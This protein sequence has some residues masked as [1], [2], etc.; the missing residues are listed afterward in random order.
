MQAILKGYI[1]KTL[2]LSKMSTIP[3]DIFIDENG[4]VI[5]SHYCRDT[6]DH[7]PMDELIEFSNG[8]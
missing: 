8:N 5:R 4:D 6:V 1:V 3:V 7:I 2:S